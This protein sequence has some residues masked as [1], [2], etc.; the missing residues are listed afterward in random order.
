ME[1]KKGWDDMKKLSLAIFAAVIIFTTNMSLA[2]AD[3]VEISEES[4]MQMARAIQNRVPNATYINVEE[5]N[6]D[7]IEKII[8]VGVPFDYSGES[9]LLSIYENGAGHVSKVYALCTFG[10]KGSI[11]KASRLVTAVFREI[12]LSESEMTALLNQHSIDGDPDKRFSDVWCQ[13]ANRRIG[14]TLALKRAEN[15]LMHSIRASDI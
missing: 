1:I 12:G 7:G 2:F 11:H 13:K 15:A 14:Y 10:D 6:E 5:S 3:V 8:V 4:G 9:A